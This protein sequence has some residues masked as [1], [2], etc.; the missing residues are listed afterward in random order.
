MGQ[1]SYNVCENPV[2]GGKTSKKRQKIAKKNVFF[3][4]LKNLTN[5]ID[6]LSLQ[7]Q[8]KCLNAPSSANRMRLY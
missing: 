8:N 4:I 5:D 7:N 3:T 1:D 2:G 6:I